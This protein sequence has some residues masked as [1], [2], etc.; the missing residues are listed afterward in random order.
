MAEN[1]G[2]CDNLVN[3]TM[4]ECLCRWGMNKRNEQEPRLLESWGSETYGWK[5]DC[6]LVGKNQ[7]DY[8]SS[9]F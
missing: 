4:K 1:S 2:R 8:D 6:G 9:L 3:I 5:N 7:M